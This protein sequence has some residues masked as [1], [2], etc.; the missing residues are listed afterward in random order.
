MVEI[1]ET[2]Q[3][4]ENTRRKIC[5]EVRIK[6]NERGNWLL[7]GGVDEWEEK[8]SKTSEI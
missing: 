6:L 3:S 5:D 1:R 4:I 2:F 7:K 8:I